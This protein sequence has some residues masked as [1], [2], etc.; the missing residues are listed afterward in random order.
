MDAEEQILLALQQKYKFRN[1]PTGIDIVANKDVKR[2][3]VFKKISFKIFKETK[4]YDLILI[5]QT[6]RFYKNKS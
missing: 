5:K 4:K 3:I 6:I 1:K 2:N